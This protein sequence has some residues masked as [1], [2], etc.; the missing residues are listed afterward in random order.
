MIKATK[1][2]SLRNSYCILTYPSVRVGGWLVTSFCRG[3]RVACYIILCRWEGGLLHPSVWVGGWLVTPFCSG[4]RVHGLLHI[5]IGVGG[6]LVTSFCAGGR[7]A[8]YIL[9]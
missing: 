3:R 6:W 2:F 5:S 8:C 4:G 7:V 1:I 9:L